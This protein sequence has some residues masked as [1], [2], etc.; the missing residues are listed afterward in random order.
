MTG[1]K[2]EIDEVLAFW[3]G[4]APGERR[5]V[6]FRRDE[7]FD[8][9]IRNRFG[10][11]HA[12]AVAGDCD[13]WAVTPRGALALIVVLDQ[14]SRN[15]FRRDPR[16]FA[17]DRKARANAKRALERAWDREFG[18]FERLFFYLPFEHSEDLDDQW[19]AVGLLSGFGE[20][21]GQ[22]AWKHLWLIQTFGRF[23]HRNAALGRRNTPA[24]DA[25]L[26]LP[27]E[28]FEAG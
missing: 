22:A 19:R 6:W 10:A 3:F 9:E 13:R 23:P 21:G 11:L 7:A 2:G 14:F 27:R 28:G 17:A 20:R 24:E 8:A 4:P 16:A 12:R 5:E 25:Y 1:Y 18:Q 15:L 26:I